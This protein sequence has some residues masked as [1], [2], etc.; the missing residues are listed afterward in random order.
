MALILGWIGLTIIAVLA[1]HKMVGGDQSTFIPTVKKE[2]IKDITSPTNNVEDI[3]VHNSQ[4]Y[5]VPVALIKA[6]IM[7]ES[8]WQVY[9]KNPSDPSYGLMGIMPIVAQDYGIVKDWKNPTT[10]EINSIYIP[11]NNIGCGSKLLSGLLKRNSMWIAV[12]CYNVG[13]RGYHEL[14]RRNGAYV[15]K[16]KNDYYTRYNGA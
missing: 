4:K 5:G 16:V 10:E 3:I 14:G 13:E 1:M 8:S 15:S 7:N 2:P 6:I 11:A 9:A 12:E